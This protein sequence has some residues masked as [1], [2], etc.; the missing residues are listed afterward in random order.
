MVSGSIVALVTPFRNGAV[1]H[2]TLAELVE[3]QIESGTS[4]VVP[5]GTTGESPTLT[6][7]EHE[8]VV[9]RVVAETAGRVPVIA[10]TGSNS[11]A[12]AVH[13]TRHAA[14]VGADAVLVVVP[15]YNRPTQ[16]GLIAH[17][18]E[19]HDCTELPLIIYNI[20]P[21]SAVDLTVD[22]MAR[23]AELPRVI[24]VKDA[25]GD[26]ARVALQRMACGP[27]FVQVS[28]EDATALGFNAQGGSGCI[29]VTANVAPAACARLQASCQAGDYATALEWQDRLMPLHR[30]LFI[31]SSPAPVKYAL[32]LL[33]RCAPDVR[34]PLVE[35]RDET[36]TAVA[37][38]MRHA[39]L[40][41][42]ADTEDG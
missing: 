10:G 30:A 29:S 24:G 12:E 11:T 25:T 18:T 15:Y 4:G 21:R 6:P 32:S 8:E 41:D 33:E 13:F 37:A 5:V 36:R 7:A 14:E 2:E 23:L 34:L 35:L 27:G 20:P 22:S 40:L 9:T 3:W 42:G 16:E 17:F 19:L 31:E 28:G 38:A 39:G 26:L 1:D